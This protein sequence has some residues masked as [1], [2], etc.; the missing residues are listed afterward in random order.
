MWIADDLRYD[1]QP[2][3]QGPGSEFQ[4]DLR[5]K[6]W[7][8]TR[9][10]SAEMANDFSSPANF[11][12][13]VVFFQR[14]EPGFEKGFHSGNHRSLLEDGIGLGPRLLIKA[15]LPPGFDSQDVDYGANGSHTD[16]NG[17][18]RFA[19]RTQG[20]LNDWPADWNVTIG[21]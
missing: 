13:F 3:Q 12:G 2:I 17:G 15:T 18:T 20:G 8:G 11:Q 1:N 7:S 9:D 10:I 21:R 14:F 6:D 5:S 4:I 16:A 19:V